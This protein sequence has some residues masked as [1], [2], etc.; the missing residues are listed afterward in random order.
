MLARIFEENIHIAIH[1][2]E[3]LRFVIERRIGEWRR[4]SGFKRK[5]VNDLG[6]REV[7]MGVPVCGQARLEECRNSQARSGPHRTANLKNI[8]GIKKKICVRGASHA[9][10]SGTLSTI[11]C[12]NRRKPPF[13]ATLSA[14]SEPVSRANFRYILP[15][16]ALPVYIPQIVADSV[17]IH[18]GTSETPHWVAS[19]P[20]ICPAPRPTPCH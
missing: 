8:S 17:T 11:F 9:T 10:V 14:K 12:G 5:F 6:P 19:F 7:N 18:R 4:R 1:G 3:F 13:H 20:S 15:I 16:S 2:S